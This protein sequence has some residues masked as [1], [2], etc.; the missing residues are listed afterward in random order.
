MNQGK[1]HFQYCSELNSNIKY[2]ENRGIIV[3]FWVTS[4]WKVCDKNITVQ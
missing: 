3:I 1:L 2:S 4:E